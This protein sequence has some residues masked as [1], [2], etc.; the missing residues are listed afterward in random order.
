[1][2]LSR[3]VD[4]VYVLDVKRD[5]LIFLVYMQAKFTDLSSKLRCMR[6]NR[7]FLLTVRQSKSDLGRTVQLT[8][9]TMSAHVFHDSCFSTNYTEIMDIF[10]A[11]LYP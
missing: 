4:H 6:T 7:G 11:F 3:K 5:R 9:I 10:N 8:L 2:S 1:M